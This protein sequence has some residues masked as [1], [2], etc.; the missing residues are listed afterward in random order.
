[1]IG[2]DCDFPG[3]NIIA[4]RIEGDTLVLCPDMRDTAG[5]WFYWAFRLRGAAGR[6]LAIRF[7][8]HTPVGMRGPALSRDGGLTW[9]W[10]TEPFTTEGFTL[11]VPQGQDDLLVTFAPLYTQAEWER[12]LAGRAPEGGWQRHV[13]CQ[14]RKGRDVEWLALGAPAE[15]ALHRVVFTA[16]HHCCE[17]IANYVMEGIIDGILADD[18]PGSWLRCQAAFCCIPFVDKDGVEDGD[19]GKNRRPRDHNRDYVGESLYPETAAIRDFL[20]RWGGTRGIAAAL[21]IHCPWIRGR[22]NDV[23]YQVG[24]E[25]PENWREQT[26]FGQFVEGALRPGALPYR[27]ADNLPFGQEWNTAAN[28]SAGMS[29]SR[30][31]AGLPGMRLPTSFEIPYAEAS[32][33]AVTADGARRFGSAVARALAA[34]LQA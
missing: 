6:R 21:D 25:A 18:E 8:A 26:R 28:F 27:T 23:I 24:R 31:S 30:W 11:T 15:T 14:S 16:R 22:N 13:L 3:G 12:F 1:M 20:P 19:Q 17:M 33:V 2:I 4:E 7:S 29:F 5:S 10:S 34:Y 32:G 9:Q